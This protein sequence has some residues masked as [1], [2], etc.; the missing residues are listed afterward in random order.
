[1]SEGDCA[2]PCDQHLLE[3][4]AEHRYTSLADLKFAVAL[5]RL[6]EA[7]PSRTEIR[8]ARDLQLDDLKQANLILIG[9]VE[10]DPWLELFQHQ[11]NFV[12]HD[13]KLAGP[14]EIE[15][16]KPMA[17]ERASYLYDGQDPR[18]RGFALVAFLPNLSGT[19]NVLV[20]QGFTLAGT[21]AA[22]EF[23]TD[24]EDFD[25]L[26][27]SIIARRHGLPHFEVLLRTMDVNGI[28][29]RPSIVAYRV[30]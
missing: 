18:H 29:S 26:F 19:G 8:F 20:V 17:G 5:T 28:G 16:R 14:L 24:H 22:A 27:G 9:S 2:Q 6:P 13:D 25:S 10:A 30:Y 12:L 1:L 21:Q 4:L 3:T 23:V 15:N 7:L 11:M